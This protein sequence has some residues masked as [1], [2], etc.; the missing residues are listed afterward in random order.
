L[1]CSNPGLISLPGHVFP[2]MAKPEA[3]LHTMAS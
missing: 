2:F 3:K 1:E